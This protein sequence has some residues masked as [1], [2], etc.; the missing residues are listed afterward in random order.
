MLKVSVTDDSAG[1]AIEVEGR[2]AGP[3]VDELQQCWL[4]E[5][6]RAAGRAISVHLSAVTF[7]D[8]AGKQLL[9]SMFQHGVEL[10]GK[11]CMVRAIVAAI[12]GRAEGECGAAPESPNE[13]RETAK[14][15]QEK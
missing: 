12:T 15:L 9:S 13:R 4:R 6:A 8:D 14:P 5:L 10:Q 11:G 2:V 1:V 7:I 3:W